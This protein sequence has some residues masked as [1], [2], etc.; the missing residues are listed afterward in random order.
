LLLSKG[1]FEGGSLGSDALGEGIHVVVE[2]VV[3]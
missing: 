1:V 2:G 3:E